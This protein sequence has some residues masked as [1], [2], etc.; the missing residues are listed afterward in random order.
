MFSALSY[1]PLVSIDLGPLSVSPHG[2]FTGVGVLVGAWLLLRDVR[3]AGYD[4]EVVTSILTRAVVA[5]LIGARLAYVVNHWSRFDSVLEVLRVWEGGASLLGG[6]TAA[7]VVAVLELR[8]R[9]M[10]VLVLLDL[11]APWFLVG[12]AVGRIGDLIIA[13]HLG[14]AT[15]SPLG[16][17]CPDVV[18]V[19]E[20]V[21]SPCPAGEVVHLT[22]L[23]DL[24]W[25]AVAALVVWSVRRRTSRV[26]VA[27]GSAGLLYGLG[28]F[29]LDGFRADAVRLGLTGSQWTGLFMILVSLAV[30]V[31][32]KPAD[33]NATTD[34]EPA[35][36]DA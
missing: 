31:T 12:I 20:T 32:S 14:T 6:L 26:G 34:A 27:I 18:D 1:D 3:R 5:A 13:D 9:R 7:L 4:A 16:F 25:A 35:E 36:V 29:V 8:R 23:Y 22:A 11:A 30:L 28:R 19:G 10:P 24:A 15:T 17:R 21:G 33:A 2:I